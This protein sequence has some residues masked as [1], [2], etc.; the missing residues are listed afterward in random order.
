[1]SVTNLDRAA[2]WKHFQRLYGRTVSLG[3]AMLAGILLP[4]A[5]AF[6]WLVPY[7]LV[8][9]LFYSFLDITITRHSFTRG[10]LWILLANL[11]IAFLAYFVLRPID[12]DLALVAFMS[13][14]TPTATAAPVIVSFLGGQVEYVIA[15]VLVTNVVV[16]LLI[17]FALPIVA[18][19]R[20]TISTWE[21]L[22]SSLF[23]VFVPLVLSRLFVYLPKTPQ[24]I[25]K[26]GKSL[27]F[28][29]WLLNLFLVTAKAAA[30]IT[31]DPFRR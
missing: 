2:R 21:V 22:Q 19:T 12:T 7:L 27:S 28:S 14:I 8:A 29:I 30:F 20:V 6:S 15:S 24:R 5:S 10:V 13:G 9:L 23:V 31:G 17:P 16:A 18:S 26:R 3:L 25:I 4:Q 11:S 1:V